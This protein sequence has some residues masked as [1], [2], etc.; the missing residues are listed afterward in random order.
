MALALANKFM[1][2]PIHALKQSSNADLE[3]YKQIIAKIYSSK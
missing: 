3:E 2:A 1:H